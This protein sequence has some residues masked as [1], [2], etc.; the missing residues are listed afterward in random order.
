ML[1][2]LTF[3]TLN[4]SGWVRVACGGESGLSDK[5]SAM[6]DGETL[7]LQSPFFRQRI[8]IFPTWSGQSTRRKIFWSFQSFIVIY[9]SFISHTIFY[10]LSAGVFKSTGVTKHHGFMPFKKK[11]IRHIVASL[12]AAK[13]IGKFLLSKSPCKEASLYLVKLF[14]MDFINV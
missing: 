9:I 12:V 1:W 7:G 2:V 11:S 5:A 13:P 14:H 4:W 3:W 8:K 6:S 10:L